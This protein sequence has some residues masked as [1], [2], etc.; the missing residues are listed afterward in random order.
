MAIASRQKTNFSGKDV[1]T[2]KVSREDTR[3][4]KTTVD[5]KSDS[6]RFIESN[7]KQNR[8]AKVKA[9]QIRKNGARVQIVEQEAVMRVTEAQ[10]PETTGRQLSASDI[11]VNFSFTIK[12]TS[13]PIPGKILSIL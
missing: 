7:D 8:I 4:G 10:Q 6:T 12:V 3:T 9:A 2:N 1:T 13:S 5:D 11:G